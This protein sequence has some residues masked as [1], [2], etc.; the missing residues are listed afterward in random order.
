M[1]FYDSKKLHKIYNFFVILFSFTAVILAF[2]DL[3]N[4]INIDISPYNYIDNSIL[5]IFTVDYFVRFIIS[6][7]KKKFFKENIFDLIA[8]IPFNS[9]FRAT[10]LFRAVKLIRLTK[11]FRLV[12]LL[13]FLEKS[14]RETKNFIYMNG[15][16][17]LIYANIITITIGAFSIYI[18]EKEA[19]VKSL[20]DA[21]WWSF[22]TATTVGY[23]DISPSTIPGRITA[24]IL[25][26]MG[27]GL[28][29][30][31]TGTISTYFISKANS[32]TKKGPLNQDYSNL[33]E[34]AQIEIE[35]FIEYIRHKYNNK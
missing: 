5:I 35:N 11:F 14:K 19:T 27:I 15:L 24:T 9:F 20:G 31:L 34:D 4:K 21:F 6:K 32:Q 7:D 25:M 28:I 22:V 33:P 17:Y 23:G 18:F 13:A 12:R 26:V 10:R 29:S 16:A 3:G 8:I 2:L 1:K 30:L